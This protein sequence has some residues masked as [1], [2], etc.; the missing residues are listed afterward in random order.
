[1]P[2]II[3]NADDDTP[4]RKAVKHSGLQHFAKM[5][6]H[7]KP[8]DHLQVTVPIPAGKYDFSV[9]ETPEGHVSLDLTAVP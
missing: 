3:V 8:G 7:K 4:D 1:M 9:S 2:S 5:N 6:Q